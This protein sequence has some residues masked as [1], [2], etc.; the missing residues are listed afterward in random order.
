MLSL[1]LCQD[2][3]RPSQQ[4]RAK[5]EKEHHERLELPLMHRADGMTRY[6]HQHICKLNRGKF[7]EVNKHELESMLLSISQLKWQLDYLSHTIR[8]LF[9]QHG[10]LDWFF[11]YTWLK[12]TQLVARA[13]PLATAISLSQRFRGP[14]APRKIHNE[15]DVIFSFH[16][17]SRLN[18]IKTCILQN[19]SRI[20]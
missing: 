12:W 11:T 14:V 13:L 9:V 2:S 3:R 1:I 17:N 6:F 4:N 16:T 5:G 10:F 15:R 7:K 19:L 20:S 18:H 8:G